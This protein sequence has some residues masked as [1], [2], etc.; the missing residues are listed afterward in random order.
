[1]YSGKWFVTPIHHIFGSEEMSMLAPGIAERAPQPYLALNKV[2]AEKLNANEGSLLQITLDGSTQSNL[3]L[4]INNGITP[5]TVGVPIG[6]PGM[7]WISIPGWAV[8]TV[9]S[10]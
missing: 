4:V 8:L 2:D 1:M 7:M 6:L 3:K 5:G 10:E 9:S